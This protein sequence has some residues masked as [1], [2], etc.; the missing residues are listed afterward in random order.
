MFV[1]VMPRRENLPVLFYTVNPP[2]E[3]ISFWL[4]TLP[5]ADVISY[6]QEKI[7]VHDKHQRKLFCISSDYIINIKPKKI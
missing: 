3:N 7:L 5:R 4:R 1:A 2:K 6:R